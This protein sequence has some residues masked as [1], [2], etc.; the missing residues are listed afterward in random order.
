MKEPQPHDS[1]N[2]IIK[3]SDYRTLALYIT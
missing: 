3:P 1:Q 2:P